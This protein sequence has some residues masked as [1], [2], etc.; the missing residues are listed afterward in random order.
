VLAVLN[1]RIV[2]FECI[3]CVVLLCLWNRGETGQ[4]IGTARVAA[5]VFTRL[6]QINSN[7]VFNYNTHGYIY[8]YIYIYILDC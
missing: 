2:L 4:S 7:F 5:F 1:L 3:G 8:I 6:Y